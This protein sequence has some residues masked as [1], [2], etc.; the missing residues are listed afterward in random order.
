MPDPV[1]VDKKDDDMETVGIEHGPRL[2]MKI[3]SSGVPLDRRRV[4]R[5]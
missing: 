1:S 5:I 3:F 2:P 4:V